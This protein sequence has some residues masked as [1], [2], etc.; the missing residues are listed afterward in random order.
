MVDDY[1]AKLT[2]AIKIVPN[3]ASIWNVDET[4]WSQD[5]QQ[6]RRYIGSV[7]AARK[8][9]GVKFFTAK[10]TSAEICSNAAGKCMP[11]MVNISIV[12]CSLISL[13]NL[14]T[15]AVHIKWIL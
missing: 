10:H 1:F 3:P 14:H 9:A 15:Y 4:G 11:I 8:L 7:G 12:F 13:I 6:N 2:E 5:Q